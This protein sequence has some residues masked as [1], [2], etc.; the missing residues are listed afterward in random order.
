MLFHLVTLVSQRLECNLEKN[1][2]HRDVVSKGKKQG[3]LLAS[4]P[5][6]YSH[7]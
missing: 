4:N 6:Y 2:P 7:S 5:M 3:Q 1:R